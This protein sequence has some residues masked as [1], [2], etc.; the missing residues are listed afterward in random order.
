MSGSAK[1]SPVETA[2]TLAVI[3]RGEHSELRV[4]RLRLVSG[5][6]VI[7][8]RSWR[9][10]WRGQVPGKGVAIRVSEAS[11]VAAALEKGSK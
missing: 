1:P 6:D 2:E 9:R 4:R 11:A 5:L 7:D 3:P 8:I 10:T